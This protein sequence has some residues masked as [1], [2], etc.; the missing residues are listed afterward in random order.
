MDDPTDDASELIATGAYDEAFALLNVVVRNPNYT[1]DMKAEAYHLLGT[2]TQIDPAFGEGDE[3]GLSYY[4]RALQLNPR[5]LWAAYGVVSTFGP[6]IPDHQDT[7][8][9]KNAMS[10]VSL[11]LDELD[12]RARDIV[13]DRY[14]TYLKITR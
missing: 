11:R 1:D 13:A 9:F 5:H 3:C 4:L 12:V 14:R 7:N 6:Q 10:A 8:A 2:L